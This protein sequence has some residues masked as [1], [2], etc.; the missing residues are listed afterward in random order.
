MKTMLRRAMARLYN[1]DRILI[2][3]NM[4]RYSV[5]HIKFLQFHLR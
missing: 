3:D 4:L 5:W 2:I 1:V